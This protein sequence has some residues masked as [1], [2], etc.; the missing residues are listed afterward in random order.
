MNASTGVGRTA[1]QVEADLAPIRAAQQALAAQSEPLLLEL[2]RAR[3][4]AHVPD[5][6]S[7]VLYAAPWDNGWFYAQNIQVTATDGTVIAW[8]DVIAELGTDAQDGDMGSA[9]LADLS[10]LYGACASQSVLDVDLVALK[11][12]EH[13]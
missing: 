3:V 13:G 9:L 2:L 7:V 8:D 12:C 10:A 5:A 11:A 6:A 1:E 4:H